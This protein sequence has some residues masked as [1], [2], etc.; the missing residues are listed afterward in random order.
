MHFA[1]PDLEALPCL[2]L[3]MECARTGGNAPCV[4]SA[5]HETAVWAFLN[6]QIG[7][8]DIYRLVASA[9]EAADVLA[10]PTLEEI[11]DSDRRAREYVRNAIE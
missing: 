3:A 6:R 1:D 11:L 2:R 7:Y 5:A 8:N 10:R 4:M 9:V